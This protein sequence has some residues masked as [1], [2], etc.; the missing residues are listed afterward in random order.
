MRFL[1][2]SNEG[3]GGILREGRFKHA[4][5]FIHRDFLQP[6]A[7][8]IRRISRS[9]NDEVEHFIGSPRAEDVCKGIITHT[10]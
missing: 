2:G 8:G 10:K 7:E 1:Y 5:N 3:W 9:F 6:S 4:S